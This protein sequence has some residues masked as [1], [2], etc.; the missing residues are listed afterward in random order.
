MRDLLAWDPQLAQASRFP[1]S[2]RSSRVLHTVEVMWLLGMGALAGLI[3]A[4][5]D[6][7][8]RIPGHAIIRGVIPIALGL[9]LVPR[10]HAG[11]CIGGGVILGIL[12]GF[13]LNGSFPGTGSFTSVTLLGPVLDQLLRW[14]Y[15]H[16]RHLYLCFAVGGLLSNYA[17]LTVRA[18]Q[19]GSGFDGPHT[20][21][22]WNWLC[23][24]LFSYAVCGALAGAISAAI[25]FQFHT[26]FDPKAT[27]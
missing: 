6:F 13:L 22:F 20:V 18:L 27:S 16:G 17:A 15:R 4:N 23:F 14:P 25:G 26:R 24:A 19:R 2:Q 1:F 7:S 10:R 8:L 21:T 9:S 3:T 5:F 11:I 12:G